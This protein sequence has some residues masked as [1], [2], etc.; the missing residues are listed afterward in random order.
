MTATSD[1]VAKLWNLCHVLRDG[2]ISYQ[3][4]VTE[5]RLVLDID[6]LDWFSAKAD[7]LGDM[8][9]RLLEKLRQARLGQQEPSP[10]RRTSRGAG[11]RVALWTCQ[12]RTID[13]MKKYGLANRR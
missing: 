12:R 5:L 10:W 8:S 11:S 6:G 9:E 2:S 4:Y 1:I 7:G 13:K 3:Q